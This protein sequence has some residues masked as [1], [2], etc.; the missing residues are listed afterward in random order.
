V[1]V[2]DIT[3]CRT[4]RKGVNVVVKVLLVLIALVNGLYAFRF[5]SDFL[6]HRKEAWAEPGNNLFLAVWGAV[7]FFLSTFGIS[8]FALSTIL[9]RAKKFVSDTKLPG[10]LNTQCAIPVAV[11]ALAYIS[12]IRVDTITLVSCIVAQMIGAYVGPRFVVKLPAGTIRKFMGAGLVVA[13]MFILAGKFN[14]VPSGGDAVG[15][16][17]SKLIIAVVLLF[18]YGAL[19]NV[20]IGSYAPTMATI[21]ALGVNP[22]VAFPIMMGA[23][24]FSV[25][26]GAMEF[27]RLGLYGRKITFF[28]SVFGIIGVLAAVFIVK[29]LNLSMIQ[30]VVAAVVLYSGG[31]MLYEE[32]FKA[33][34]LCE[35]EA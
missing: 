31:S 21:Y 35:S 8:D 7:V 17:G 5:A 12:T 19:N 28:S 11:M 16:T 26:M 27:V 34:K 13:A 24:T 25:P 22:A 4:N 29:S 10:T 1:N 30:W 14:L 33:K 32:L 18:I 2:I 15:L 20:G 23:C 9:Y 6:K 3:I